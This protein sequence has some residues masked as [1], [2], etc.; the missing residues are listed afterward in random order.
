VKTELVRVTLLYGGL[1]GLLLT[2]LGALVSASRGKVQSF[3]GG[4]VTPDLHRVI[5]AHGN[6]AEWIPPFIVLLAL[7]ELGG[8]GSLALHL[9]GG[10]FLLGRVLH[11]FGVLKKNPA[12]V[13]GATIT[14]GIMVVTG[15]WAV[16]AHFG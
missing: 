3:V 12:S 11:A 9:L 13:A 5:R 14:Y 15:V 4:Q 7:L 16:V 8:V 10:G 1:L 2:S 6:A